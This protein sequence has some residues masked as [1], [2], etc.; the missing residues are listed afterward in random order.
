MGIAQTRIYKTWQSAK[1]R[2]HR[3]KT[4]GYQNYGGKGIKFCQEWHD[5]NVFKEWALDNGYNDEMF[6]VRIELDRDYSP[7]NCKLVSAEEKKELDKV[8]PP[9]NDLVGKRFGK[10]TVLNDYL[11]IPNGTKWKC[12]CDCGNETYVYR[13][14]LI[15]GHTSSCG[16][17]SRSLEGLSNSR[18][19]KTWWGI[20]ERCY[21]PNST[22]YHNYGLKGI[23]LCEEWHDFMNFYNWSMENGY[24]DELTIDRLDSK[25]DYSP[26]NCQWIS[27]AKNVAKA[28][29]ENHRRKT[30]FKY[31][32]ISP[33]GEKFEFSNANQF[34][35]EQELNAECIRKT[36]KGE[37]NFH[38]GWRFGYT[39]KRNV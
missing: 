20:K 2:C 32:G 38:K 21:S 33:T 10:L 16:C 15:T 11:K 29:K 23:R 13:G 26:D 17:T 39:N 31:Y 36:A 24:S 18:I 19:Y 28:N 30:E 4:K 12:K 3:P 35:R 6:L 7:E 25:K 22:N 27:L 9:K 34:A 37:R 1:D 5:F 8:K 14:K